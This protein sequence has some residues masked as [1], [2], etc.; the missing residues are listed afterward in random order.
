MLAT[1]PLM[2]NAE[3]NRLRKAI[4]HLSPPDRAWLTVR[5][6]LEYRERPTFADLIEQSLRIVKESERLLARS[7]ET[8]HG[9][10][11]LLIGSGPRG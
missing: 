10:A 11:G 5:L 6:S 2:T 7:R 4:R 3:R 1:Y 8:D 9:L